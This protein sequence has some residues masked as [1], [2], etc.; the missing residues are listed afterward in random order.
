VKHI[1]EIREAGLEMPSVNQIEVS[2]CEFHV[3]TVFSARFAD[4]TSSFIPSIS[5]KPLSTTAIRTPSSFKRTVRL[6]A[7]RWTSRR[8]LKSPKRYVQIQPA[9]RLVC[10]H[11]CLQHNREP[12]QVLIRWSLQRG[13]ADRAHPPL[14]AGLT[15]AQIRA[16]P[17]IGDAGAHPL[18]C[19]RLRL[20]AVRGGHGEDRRARQGQGGQHLVGPGRRCV[21]IAG[22][23]CMS[24][25]HCS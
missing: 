6:C 14:R 19:G 3:D 10:A 13:C 9:R 11:S 21:D 23:G 2:F 17:E 24:Q 25:S 12:A 20:R 16:A 4:I 7:E 22:A 8:S 1:E 5:R 15:L 18:E